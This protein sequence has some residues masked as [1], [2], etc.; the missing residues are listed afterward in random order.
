[1]YKYEQVLAPLHT[2]TPVTPMFTF[3]ILHVPSFFSH[4]TIYDIHNV[5]LP[6]YATSQMLYEAQGNESKRKCGLHAIMN[7][8]EQVLVPLIREESNYCTIYCAIY[9]YCTLLY[10][11]V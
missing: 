3:A 10:V 5:V 11:M 1:M 9:H 7:K 4:C 8:Y 6:T 2:S